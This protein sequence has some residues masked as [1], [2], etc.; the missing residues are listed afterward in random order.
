MENTRIVDSRRWE[1]RG[2]RF[3]CCVQPALE[4]L[5][6]FLQWLQVLSGS[7]W[8]IAGS[9]MRTSLGTAVCAHLH[10]LTG[11]SAPVAALSPGRDWGREIAEYD[12]MSA[13]RFVSC[14]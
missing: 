4:C 8:S 7:T 1:G 6:E 12:A 3:T 9:I 14:G 13:M 2:R 10:S 5:L 11:S